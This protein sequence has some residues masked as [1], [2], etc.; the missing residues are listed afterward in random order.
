MEKTEII[1]QCIEADCEWS[2]TPEEC[3]YDYEYNEFNGR[4]YKYYICPSCEGG[5]DVQEIEIED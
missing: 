5:I 4:D 2:G 1:A 3:D